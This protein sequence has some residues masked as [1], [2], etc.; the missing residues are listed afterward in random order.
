MSVPIWQHVL[1]VLA[2]LVTNATTFTIC[3]RRV[4]ELKAGLL[5]KDVLLGVDDSLAWAWIPPNR[6]MVLTTERP[7][8][9]IKIT[10]LHGTRLKVETE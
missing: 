1:V 6:A 9:R 8:R 7:V 3:K 4:E 2:L 5:A 10:S